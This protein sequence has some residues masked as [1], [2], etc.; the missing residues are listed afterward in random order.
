MQ[1]GI[2]GRGGLYLD[3]KV[4]LSRVGRFCLS[5]ELLANR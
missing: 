3:I 1:E 4:G 2:L 5:G